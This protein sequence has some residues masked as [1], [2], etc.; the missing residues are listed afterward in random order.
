MEQDI[1][2]LIVKQ[3]MDELKVM[4]NYSGRY[5]YGNIESGVKY[6]NLNVLIECIIAATIENPD[7]MCDFDYNSIDN[8]GLEFIIY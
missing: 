8:M 5:M 4:R 6:P 3:N 2:E 1:A 7:I